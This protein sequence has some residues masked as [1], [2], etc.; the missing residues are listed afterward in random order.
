[1][2]GYTGPA[3]AGLLCLLARS[4]AASPIDVDAG[5]RGFKFL[6][7][8]PDARVAGLGF[9]ATTAAM[10][11][12]TALATNPAGLAGIGGFSA[13]ATHV[14]WLATIRDEYL[15]A[16]LPGFGG[17]FGVALRTQ[18]SGDIPLRNLDS[19][20][21]L[22]T[23]GVHDAALTVAYARRSGPVAWGVGLNLIHE[24]IYLDG[25][26]AYA[27]DFGLAWSANRWSAG[28]ALHSVGRSGRL[29]AQRV[30]LP[31][32]AQAGAA[33]R[34]PLGTHALTTVADVRYAPD[35]DET[36]HLGLEADLT[37]M[38][39]LRVGYRTPFRELTG[40]AGLTAGVG[41][42]LGPVGLDYAYI[43]ERDG[44][45]AGHLFTLAFGRR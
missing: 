36:L 22:G 21:P 44:L 1:M 31:W 9:A 38:L 42:R 2:R 8:L 12:P 26:T 41:L 34:L 3:V 32:D 40:A 25:V 28:A 30:P 10:S 45:G 14:E 29:D 4:L 5:S 20:D 6:Q 19:P 18:S 43:P 35:Y 15:G 39:A 24:K 11:S 37:R 33:Y 23:Y 7:I 13:S 27:A 16:A 17:A